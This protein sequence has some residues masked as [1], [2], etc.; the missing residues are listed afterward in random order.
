[1]GNILY[2]AKRP[3]KGGMMEVSHNRE[4]ITGDELAMFGAAS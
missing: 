4:L 1:M 2:I 3:L